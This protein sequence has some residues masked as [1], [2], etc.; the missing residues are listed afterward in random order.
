S[1]VL[2]S[3]GSFYKLRVLVVAI[4][5]DQADDKTGGCPA[6]RD[7]PHDGQ[8]RKPDTAV[9]TSAEDE[10]CRAGYSQRGQR[11]LPDEFADVAFPPTQ[12]LIR[13][14]RDGLCRTIHGARSGNAPND[15]RGDVADRK[16]GRDCQP[17]LAAHELARVKVSSLVLDELLRR[18][19]AVLDRLG[20]L[21]RRLPALIH[22]AS[23]P[24]ICG[25]FHC[26][27]YYP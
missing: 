10:S 24:R 14:R 5:G 11:F 18:L 25:F 26:H 12:P 27:S 7:P 19:V 8:Q 1:I 13:I 17:R 23:N 20:G 22:C 4:A 2:V 21:V 9:G 15:L 6:Q 3:A 16:R